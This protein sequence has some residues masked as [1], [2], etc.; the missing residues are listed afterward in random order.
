MQRT[1]NLT[2]LMLSLVVVAWARFFVGHSPNGVRRL[3]GSEPTES[4]TAASLTLPAEFIA[5][6]LKNISKGHGNPRVDARS[7]RAEPLGQW[8]LYFILVPCSDRYGKSWRC[9]LC[10]TTSARSSYSSLSNCERLRV[11]G[12]GAPKATVLSTSLAQW[13]YTLERQLSSSP[14][15]PRLGDWVVSGVRRKAPALLRLPR[16]SSRCA[17]PQPFW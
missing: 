13:T 5:Q 8:V 7:V 6:L 16:T 10:G 1:G 17:K 2:I 15:M 14:F 12:Q 3:V 9:C 4:A 11:D